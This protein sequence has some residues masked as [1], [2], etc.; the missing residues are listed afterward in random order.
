MCERIDPKERRS[1]VSSKRP[2]DGTTMVQNHRENI[3]Q[4]MTPLS[5]YGWNTR[6]VT[7]KEGMEDGRLEQEA[8]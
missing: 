5:E 8:R 4:K 2:V 1:S 7:N 6:T 3:T